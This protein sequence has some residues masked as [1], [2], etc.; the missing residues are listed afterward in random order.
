[1]D[2]PL[3]GSLFCHF[4]WAVILLRQGT[5]E[6]RGGVWFGEETCGLRNVCLHFNSVTVPTISLAS[7]S[8]WHILASYL[9]GLF[10]FLLDAQL[11]PV[12]SL[13]YIQT[14]LYDKFW[15]MEC[16]LRPVTLQSA[17]II[18][19]MILQDPFACLWLYSDTDGWH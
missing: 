15:S 9:P 10:S 6:I 3:L 14:C 18:I 13:P 5:Y 12:P 8:I 1:M 2:Q 19:L 16:G 4:L 11:N 7:Y 17:W